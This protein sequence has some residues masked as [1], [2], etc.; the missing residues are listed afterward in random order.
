MEIVRVKDYE[1]MSKT[2][3]NYILKK[4]VEKESPVLGLATGSTPEGLYR[5]LVDEYKKGN[6]SFKHVQTF[7]LDEYT[8]LDP[9][10]INSYHYFM[11]KH[12]F[13][14]IDI[15]KDQIHLP[16]GNAS[17]LEDECHN[18]ENKISE[19]G[20]IDLQLL[21]IGING[22][23]GFNEPG[24]PFTSRTHIV[25][26][27]ESTRKANSRFFPS[28]DDVPTHAITM[29]IESIM[30]SK[31]ILLLVSGEMKADT[32]NRLMNG[33]VSEDFPASILHKHPKVT[34]IADEAACSKLE[35]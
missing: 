25:T 2:A 16:N 6:V 21:G 15:P 31:E 33:E 3:S 11:N 22:H 7:N 26:L 14:H 4:V 8:K 19:A 18:Y 13:E 23:I 32:L 34:I 20:K 5:H 28:I 35:D 29:G 1:E 30:E 12:L 27:D 24:T 9:T 17:D 10:D